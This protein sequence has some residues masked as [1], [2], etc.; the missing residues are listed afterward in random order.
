MCLQRD[1]YYKFVHLIPLAVLEKYQDNEPVLDKFTN[2]FYFSLVLMVLRADI[3]DTEKGTETVSTYHDA[4]PLRK[5]LCYLSHFVNSSQHNK[6][7]KR[8]NL[9]VL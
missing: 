1:Y 6:C 8:K 7:N 9:F 2:S 3:Q 4:C 5:R